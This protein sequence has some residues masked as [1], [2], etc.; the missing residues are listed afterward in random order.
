LEI[1]TD[2]ELRN[3]SGKKRK[4][5]ELG[6]GGNVKY[7]KYNAIAFKKGGRVKRVRCKLATGGFLSFPATGKFVKLSDYYKT[8]PDKNLLVGLKVYDEVNEEYIYIKS[9]EDG[10]FAGK[11]KNDDYGH[12]YSMPYLLVDKK[13][14]S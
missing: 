8:L 9:V 13:Y 4:R 1:L 2:E 7:D 5:F 3:K 6:S 10:I 14:L 11:N 12:Y